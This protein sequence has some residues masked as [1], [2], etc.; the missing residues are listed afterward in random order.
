MTITRL[1]TV[2]EIPQEKRVLCQAAGCGRGVYKR[3]HVVEDDGQLTVLG[4]D[5]FQRLYGHL[6]GDA[7][8]PRYGSSDGRR[9][10]EAERQMLLG[11]TQRFIEQLEAERLQQEQMKLERDATERRNAEQ[12]QEIARQKLSRL[13]AEFER[14]KRRLPYDEWLEQLTPNQRQAFGIVRSQAREAIRAKYDINPD[15]PG[16]VGMVNQEARSRYE[17]EFKG[18]V[19]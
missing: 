9:L 5:C 4:S 6:D 19:R 12:Q 15:L 16:F 8:K 1:L 10:T 14:Q 17:V 13:K 18:A 11:N 3:I 2:V 7:V